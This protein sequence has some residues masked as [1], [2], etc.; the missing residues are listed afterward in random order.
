M[1]A[2]G[3]LQLRAHHLGNSRLEGDSEVEGTQEG[4]FERTKHESR[5]RSK[6]KHGVSEYRAAILRNDRAFSSHRPSAAGT[7]IRSVM[8]QAKECG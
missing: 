3:R 2:V 5:H 8:L 1:S 7:E 4:D 6:V